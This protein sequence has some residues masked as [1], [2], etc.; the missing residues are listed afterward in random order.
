MTYTVTI[1]QRLGERSRESTDLYG[2][3][4]NSY[5]P[6]QYKGRN[7]VTHSL[8]GYEHYIE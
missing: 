8:N 1:A 4:Q 6:Y 5:S 2:E 7:T 3:L